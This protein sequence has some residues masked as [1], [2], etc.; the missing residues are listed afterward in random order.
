MSAVFR[1]HYPSMFRDDAR[2]DGGLPA[3]G[4]WEQDVDR[5]VGLA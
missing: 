3:G 5:E 2:R 4:D 1:E